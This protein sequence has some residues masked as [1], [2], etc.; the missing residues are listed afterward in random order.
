MGRPVAGRIGD[1]DPRPKEPHIVVDLGDR[2]DR[3]ARVP[4]GGLLLDGDR[5]RQAF[6][7]VDVRLLHHVE[8]LAGVGRERLD[9]AALAFGID[10][11]E[12]ERALARA[13][14]AGQ[15]DKLLAWQVEG[16]VLEVVLARAADGDEFGGHSSRN[17]GARGPFGKPCKGLVPNR[18]AA[19]R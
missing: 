10:G 18:F 17:V 8:E 3:G 5:R 11:V 12:G 6:D 15:H 13:G 16:D 2:A 14:Q 7:V 19:A 1:A 4:R 9:I